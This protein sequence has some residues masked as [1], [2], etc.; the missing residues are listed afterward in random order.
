MAATLSDG[1][2]PFNTKAISKTILF[3]VAATNMNSTLIAH[4]AD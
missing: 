4:D 1:V 2:Q 3:V